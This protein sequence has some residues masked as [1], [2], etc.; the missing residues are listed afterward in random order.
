MNYTRRRRAAS[1]VRASLFTR[2]RNRFRRRRPKTVAVP[3]TWLI[4]QKR[5]MIGNDPE[6]Y[7][8]ADQ[9]TQPLSCVDPAAMTVAVPA[10]DHWFYVDETIAVPTK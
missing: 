7:D 9:P 5:A 3:S 2:L 1:A 6:L 10:Y 4:D 8:I